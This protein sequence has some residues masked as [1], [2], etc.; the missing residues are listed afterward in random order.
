MK[1][2]VAILLCLVLLITTGAVASAA[3]EA[4][5]L[6][7]A[8]MDI[9]A[10]LDDFP[11]LY[12]ETPMGAHDL[13]VVAQNADKVAKML[14]TLASYAEAREKARLDSKSTTDDIKAADASFEQ[15]LK[16]AKSNYEGLLTEDLD[17]IAVPYVDPDG[18]TKYI[19]IE[20]EYEILFDIEKYNPNSSDLKGFAGEGG[21]SYFLRNLSEQARALKLTAARKAM[22]AELDCAYRRSD[23]TQMDYTSLLIGLAKAKA[24]EAAAVATEGLVTAK[25][26]AAQA[27][28]TAKNLVFDALLVARDSAQTAIYNA[29]MAAYNELTNAYVTAVTETWTATQSYLGA[30]GLSF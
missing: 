28:A 9:R 7:R 5:D 10:E 27:Q 4:A 23:K 17:D 25:E 12:W 18:K 30:L 3:D 26:M 20:E 29:Q 14:D 22:E 1:R 15:Q 11:E 13:R 21:N 6:Q 8:Y 16:K 24:G 19:E 2:I